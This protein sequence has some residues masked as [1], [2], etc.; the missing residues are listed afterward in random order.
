[1]IFF[2]YTNVPLCDLYFIYDRSR[3]K[4]QTISTDKRLEVRFFSLLLL[5]RVNW[6]FESSIYCAALAW[7]GASVYTALAVFAHK[8]LIE[9]RVF[10]SVPC[11]ALCFGAVY[12]I[13]WNCCHGNM[14]PQSGECVYMCVR[15][16][17]CRSSSRKWT[18]LVFHWFHAPLLVAADTP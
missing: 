3:W 8:S 1:M 13:Y 17:S 4:I 15:A 18:A 6:P 10:R 11:V 5:I 16:C 14:F 9:G 7:T 12:C 2:L